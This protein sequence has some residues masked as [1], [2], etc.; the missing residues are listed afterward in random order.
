ME[1]PMF[2]AN[3]A[4]AA[5]TPAG[6]AP[7]PLD[8]YGSPYQTQQQPYITPSQ[9]TIVDPS[10]SPGLAFIL[11]FI[12][13]VGAIYNG[14]YAKGLIHV[15]ILGIIITMLESQELRGF[16]PLFG[17]SLAAFMFYQCFE[18]YHTAKRRMMGQ[19]VDEFSSLIAIDDNKFPVGPVVLIGAGVFFLLANFDLIRVRDVIRFWPLGL[20]GV[21]AYML[22]ARMN[23]RSKSE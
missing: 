11:G 9:Q 20:I 3:P 8:P 16:E 21:G 14:Q 7:P 12:P 1:T 10:V 17:L 5:A 6:A 19:K 23:A 2:T 22:Y 4:A 18:A 13:G 15:V